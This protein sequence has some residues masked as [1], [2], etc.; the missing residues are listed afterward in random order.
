MNNPILTDAAIRQ[1]SLRESAQALNE[2]TD[3]LG[4]G[5]FADY[6]EE[7]YGDSEEA[8]QRRSDNEDYQAWRRS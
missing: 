4:L 1:L 5:W 8:R 2:A 6:L 3:S 7:L